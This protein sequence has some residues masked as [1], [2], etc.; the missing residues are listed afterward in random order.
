MPPK[1]KPCSCGSV[2]RHNNQPHPCFKHSKNL[3]V[4]K[5]ED[6][7][8]AWAPSECEVC[9]SIVHE[10]LSGQGDIKSNASE[11]WKMLCKGVKAF[12]QRVSIYKVFTLRSSVLFNPTW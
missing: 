2:S 1:D 8:R 5:L 9:I 11:N 3:C 10:M 6:G 7:G 4:K 12:A